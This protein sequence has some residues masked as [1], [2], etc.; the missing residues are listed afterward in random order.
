MISAYLYHETRI[1]P[2]TTSLVGAGLLIALI[3]VLVFEFV[4][5]HLTGFALILTVYATTLVIFSPLYVFSNLV[6]EAEL[7]MMFRIVRE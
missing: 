6:D 1:H 7:T 5:P 3:S 2:F 4:S